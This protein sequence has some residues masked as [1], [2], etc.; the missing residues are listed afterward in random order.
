MRREVTNGQEAYSLAICN[1][2]N[3]LSKGLPAMARPAVIAALGVIIRQEVQPWLLVI[4]VALWLPLSVRE[5]HAALRSA[6]H[7]A[8]IC[9]GAV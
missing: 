2:W 7:Q 9:T 5:G 8:R 3:A 6:V 1:I 4:A